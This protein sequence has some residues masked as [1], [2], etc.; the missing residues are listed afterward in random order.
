[1]KSKEHDGYVGGPNSDAPRPPK[2]PGITT[3]NQIKVD[4]HEF[5]HYLKQKLKECER[6]VMFYDRLIVTARQFLHDYYGQK[7]G[8]SDEAN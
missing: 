4:T 8:G 2:T 6:E 5:I 3:T 1:M 7:D